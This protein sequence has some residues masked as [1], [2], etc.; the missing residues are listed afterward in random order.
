MTAMTGAAGNEFWR[1]GKVWMSAVAVVTGIAGW[2]VYDAMMAPSWMR[3]FGLD[4]AAR[5]EIVAI[6]QQ[7]TAFSTM[8]GR[9]EPE[10]PYICF[11]NSAKFEWDRVYFV[12]SGGPVPGSIA[13]FEWQDGV[14]ADINRRMAED[15][16]YQLIAFER[17]G[18][19]VEH[20]Y[21]FTMWADLTEI[22]RPTGFSRTDAVFIAES[23]G[24]TYAVMPVKQAG[25][26][27]CL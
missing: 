23:N 20:E 18:T 19:V 2:M 10:S 4:I 24:E 15:S 8:Q 12:Q 9:A 14:V 11:S 22:A 7:E 21:Y 27:S 25:A 6:N 16:R 13:G 3:D 26:S 1:Q 17:G 5:A